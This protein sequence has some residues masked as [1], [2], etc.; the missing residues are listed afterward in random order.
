MAH[1]WQDVR[2]GM[3]VLGKRPGF[4]LVAI[5]MLALGI[6]ANTALFSVLDAV[7]LKPLPYADPDRLLAV[8]ERPPQFSRNS[9][10]NENFLNWREQNRVFAAM[11]ATSGTPT[12]VPDCAPDDEPASAVRAAATPSVSIT[13]Q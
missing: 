1:L 4:T 3:R 11:S 10:A 8:W 9:V 13:V 6:G 5:L 12:W 2:Y 7:L